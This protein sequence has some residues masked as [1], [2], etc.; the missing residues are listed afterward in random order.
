MS[1]TGRH[2]DRESPASTNDWLAAIRRDWDTRARE[3]PR[4]YINWP[5]IPNEEGAFFASGRCDYERFVKPFLKKMEFDP[6]DK[7]A[8]EIGCGIGRI[9]RWM[10]ADFDNY[11]GVDVSPEMVR[12]ATL[13]GFPRATFQAVSGADLRGIPTGSIDFVF[14]FAV[15]QHVPDK[16]SIFGYFAESARV[17]RHGGIFRLHMKGLWSASLGRLALE[18]GFSSQPRLL[19]AGL[20]RIPI[21]RLRYMD[22]WQGRSIRPT[23]AVEKCDSLGLEVQD[24]EGPGTT[25]MWVGGRKK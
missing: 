19:K 14:S 16:A 21:L 20:T 6:R 3:N 5:D 7:A 12:K 11:I 17:L 24:L 8:L 4:A 18:A 9:A 25:M 13:Y 10:A 23:E 22:T 2:L 1:K 15:F